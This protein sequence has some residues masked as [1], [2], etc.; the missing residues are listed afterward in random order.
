MHVVLV[1]LSILFFAST[2]SPSAKA[3]TPLPTPEKPAPDVIVFV[4]G[5]QLT[6]KLERGVGDSVIFNSDMTGEVTIPL[7]K[8]KEL[9]S[10]SNFAVLRKGILL[11][12]VKITPSPI[13]VD[14]GKVVVSPANAPVE[15]IPSGDLNYIIDA[16]TY[17]KEL[18]GHHKFSDGWNGSLTGGITIVNGTQVGNSYN[19]GVAV[20]RAIPTAPW[21]PP[22]DRTIIGLIETY[23]KISQPVIPQTTP[24]SPDTVVK[25][26]ILHAVFE[27]DRY[28]TSRFF[29]LGTAVFDHNYAQGLQLSQLYGGGFGYTL[30]KTANTQFDVTANVHY[31]RQA[32]QIASSNQN[33]IG[34]SFGENLVH[35]LP[36]K[37]VFTESG[38]YLPAFNNFDAYSAN[39]LAGLALPVYHRFSFAF[40]ATD[41]YI[42]NPSPGYKAN[43]FQFVTGVTYNLH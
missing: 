42:N 17:N 33:L 7:S 21:L 8:I 2:L 40:T 23:G 22:R 28:L 5:D 24:P 29:L 34:M 12:K 4:N 18:A 39:L 43:S 14:D 35:N 41:N 15:T 31:Q 19:A 27:Q 9:H 3:Q 37:I 10:G 13:K 30:V 6:G 25:T 16:D 1:G 11:N 32:F 26:N 36:H 38:T 20:T